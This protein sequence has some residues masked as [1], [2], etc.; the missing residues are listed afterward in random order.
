[1]VTFVAPAYPRAARQA[2]M[3]GNTITELSVNQKGVVTEAKRILGHAIFEQYVL[4]ALRQWRFKP[5]G[6]EY[7]F[8]VTCLFELTTDECEGT[9]ERP[10]TETHVSAELPALVRV[11]TSRR[12]IQA[13]VSQR[14][15]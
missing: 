1:M 14:K 5:S 13:D 10:A 2:G 6:Q 3:Q 15:R 11:T 7:T 4:A 8:Q 9:A 12:C